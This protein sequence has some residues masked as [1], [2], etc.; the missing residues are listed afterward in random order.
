MH[1]GRKVAAKVSGK[2]AKA[3]PK[4]LAAA[5]TFDILRNGFIRHLLNEKSD[6]YEETA[7]GKKLVRNK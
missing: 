1:F 6:F 7:I 3:G 2:L 5:A 4:G